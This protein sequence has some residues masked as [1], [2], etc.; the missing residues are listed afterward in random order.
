MIKPFNPSPA[1]TIAVAHATSATTP[2]VLPDGCDTL[3]IYNSSDTATAFLRI[4]NLTSESASGAN[5]AIPVAGG[6][7]GDFPIPP[8]MLIRIS[9]AAGPKKFSIISTAEDGGNPV[10]FTPGTGN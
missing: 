8:M 1:G 9:C 7:K 6:A 10:Y 3:A 5:A 2:A 4:A